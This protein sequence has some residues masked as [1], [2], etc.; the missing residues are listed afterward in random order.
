MASS[1]AT[2]S[3]SNDMNLISGQSANLSLDLLHT[4]V[5]EISVSPLGQWKKLPQ[6][7]DAY[8]ADTDPSERQHGM[9]LFHLFDKL[10]N[11]EAKL[12]AADATVH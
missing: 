11:I 12:R 4:H 5:I 7:D 3:S 8:F 2:L 9:R 10:N 6:P 1:D